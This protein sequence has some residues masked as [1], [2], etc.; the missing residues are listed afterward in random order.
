[1]KRILITGVAGFIGSNLAKKLLEDKNNQIIG[2]DN[3]LSGQKTN[4]LPIINNPN[5]LFINHDINDK[6]N[7]FVDEIYNCAC[8]ASPI[9]YQKYPIETTK[10]CTIGV[11]NLLE[12]AKENN[13]KIMQF[14]TSEIYGNPL[15]HP[16]IEEYW[17]NVNPIGIRSC[18]D[19]GKRCAETLMFNYYR[20]YNVNIKIIRIFNTYGPGMR[21]DDGR[22]IPNFI[23]QALKNNNITIYGDG[24]QTRS[25]CYIDDLINGI[26]K[27]ME[28][29]NFIGPVNL[30]NPEEYTMSEL[31]KKIIKLTNSKS[32]IEYL[33]LPKDDPIKR[34]PNISLAIEKLNW[35]PSIILNN[36]LEK[37][38]NYFKEVL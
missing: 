15:I 7:F 29:D 20:Q 6:I 16:Q 21:Y 10:V 11:M 5:F 14:S 13:A 17:G 4:L 31:A 22:V 24:T 26:I 12:L 33:N 38:I 34:K 35:K 8:L 2:V 36:G 3:F 9:F 19:E 28:C 32:K 30:G 1:M 18:Y 23:C 25:F 27:M 37:T